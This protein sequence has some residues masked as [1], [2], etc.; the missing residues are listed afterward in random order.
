MGCPLQ[1]PRTRA[2]LAAHSASSLLL[3]PLWTNPSADSRRMQKAACWPLEETEG[4]LAGS[5]RSTYDPQRV[6]TLNIFPYQAIGGFDSA[7]T[8]SA[9]AAAEHT[10][11]TRRSEYPRRWACELR[12]RPTARPWD[13]SRNLAPLG[14]GM[15]L[16]ARKSRHCWLRDV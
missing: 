10:V 12:G 8:A 7:T 15:V 4:C 11:Q 16:V 2:R 1:L 9:S 13:I 6:A 5:T 14:V 3:K